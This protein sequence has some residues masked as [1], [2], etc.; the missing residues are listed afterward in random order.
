M[1][2]PDPLTGKPMVRCPDTQV[3]EIEPFVASLRAVPR[4]G[5]HNPLKHPE[6]YLMLG[7]VTALAAETMR[8]DEVAQHFA[9]LIQRTSPKS[10][11]Q[12][13]GEVTVTRKF[14]ENFC[15][16]QPR[17]LARSFSVPGDHL[18]QQSNGYRW[19]YGPVALIA[20]FNFPLEIPVLQ[21]M[22]A[23]YMG[24]KPLVHVDRR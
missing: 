21:L 10:S 19:P 7:Q 8:K 9:R 4:T 14:L 12:A 11:A 13:L 23:L 17:F 16:D 2:I 6:R 15:G 18:G 1:E 20:P 3:Y 22:G 24:N 5:L